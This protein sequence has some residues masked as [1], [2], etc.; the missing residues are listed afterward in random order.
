MIAENLL[1]RGLSV[2][3]MVR[4]PFELDKQGFTTAEE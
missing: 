4:K 3:V 1:R 2:M